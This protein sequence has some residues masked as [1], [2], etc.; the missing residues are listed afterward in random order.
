MRDGE[1]IEAPPRRAPSARAPAA[2]WSVRVPTSTFAEVDAHPHQCDTATPRRA[3]S[4][5]RYLAPTQL[6]AARIRRRVDS[7]RVRPPRHDDHRLPV[8]ARQAPLRRA[9]T[10]ERRASGATTLSRRLGRTSRRPHEL[11][12]APTTRHCSVARYENGVGGRTKAGD[13]RSGEFSRLAACTTT[14]PNPAAIATC[15]RNRTWTPKNP[16]RTRRHT[17]IH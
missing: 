10:R 17:P 2:R 14:P 6:D 4:Q 3:I 11:H 1:R 15:V 5:H 8:R 13:G 16:V 12:H 7:H 9:G